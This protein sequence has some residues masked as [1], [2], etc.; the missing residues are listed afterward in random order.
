MNVAAEQTA[1]LS[2]TDRPITGF[3]YLQVLDFMTTV[4]FLAN[5]VMEGNPFVRF[6]M[7]N[8]SHPLL[9]LMAAK[10]LAIMLGMYAWRTGRHAVLRKAN[11]FFAAL[12]VWNLI[13]TIVGSA[14]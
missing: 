7:Q 4:A 14:G 6:L 9:G 11:V 3:V 1:T 2:L 8:T 13:G 10:C 12:V 5:G